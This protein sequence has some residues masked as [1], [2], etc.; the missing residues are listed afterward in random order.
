MRHMIKKT[1]K[2]PIVGTSSG[3]SL[4]PDNRAG[5]CDPIVQTDIT[6][7]RSGAVTNVGPNDDEQWLRT[8]LESLQGR[9]DEVKE[10]LAKALSNGHQPPL[11]PHGASSFPVF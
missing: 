3:K 11:A 5:N 10:A 9:S 4:E 7:N 1:A 8:V 6:E 2:P